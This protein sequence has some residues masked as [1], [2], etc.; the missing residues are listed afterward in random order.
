MRSRVVGLA[1]AVLAAWLPT[2]IAR[3]EPGSLREQIVGT[4][5][6]VFVDVVRPDGTRQPMYGP[7]PRGIAVFDAAGH[8]MLLTA[9]AEL[10]KFAVNNRL[11]GTADENR[12]V[13]HGSI[14]HF[15]RYEVDDAA[16][17]ITFHIET[18]TF[19]NWNGTDQR[20]PASISGDTLTWMTPGSSGGTAEVVL[21]RAR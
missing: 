21:Q 9:R 4:W 13:V 1:I 16:R 6:Y 20:R 10:A 5:T 7:H 8:Y 3:A 11:E 19:P 12:A 15:G 14:A 18:S 2:A 17:T